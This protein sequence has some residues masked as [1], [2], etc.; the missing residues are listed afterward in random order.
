MS[1]RSSLRGD[2]EDAVGVDLELHLHARHA[3]RHRRNAAQL[4]ARQRSVVGDQLALALQHVDVD[5]GLVVD[6]RS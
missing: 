5:G 4:E 1:V 6:A 2:A 3:G